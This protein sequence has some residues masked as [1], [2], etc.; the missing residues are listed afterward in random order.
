MVVDAAVS[1][2]SAASLDQRSPALGFRKTTAADGS[3]DHITLVELRR[4]TARL[5]GVT[6]KH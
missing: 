4:L 6:K 2:L 5:S 1:V 3:D